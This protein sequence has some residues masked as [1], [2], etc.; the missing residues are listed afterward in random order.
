MKKTSS[1]SPTYLITGGAGFIG[2]HLM[3][4]LLAGGHPVLAID[5]LS[6]GNPRNISHL[7]ENPNFQFARASITDAV[8]IDRLASQADI[9]V[10]LAAAVGVNLIIQN[11]VHTIETNI[12]GSDAILKAALR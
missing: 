1:Q 6:T 10:H 9:I 4:A 8:V 3:D 12:L 5:D 11:P 2:S 7:L